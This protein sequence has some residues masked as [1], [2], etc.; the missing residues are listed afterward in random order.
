M[1]KKAKEDES[2]RNKVVINA[3]EAFLKYYY[4]KEEGR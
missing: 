4:G 3:C 2:S 1:D